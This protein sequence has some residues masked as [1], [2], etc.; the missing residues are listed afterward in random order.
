MASSLDGG[1]G[2]P[3]VEP[4]GGGCCDTSIFLGESVLLHSS[5]IALQLTYVE[6][7]CCRCT[8]NVDKVMRIEVGAEGRSGSRECC[9]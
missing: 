4:E 6:L 2:E 1:V 7:C 5:H 3:I 9:E 8:A